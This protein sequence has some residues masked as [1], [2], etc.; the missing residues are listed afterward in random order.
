MNGGLSVILKA[1]SGGTGS[2]DCFGLNLAQTLHS[3]IAFFVFMQKTALRDV[4]SFGFDF[5][6]KIDSLNVSE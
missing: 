3:R 6:R 5:A 2:V 4:S 1:G